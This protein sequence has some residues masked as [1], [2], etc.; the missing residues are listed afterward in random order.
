MAD[1]GEKKP[2]NESAEGAKKPSD[3]NPTKLADITEIPT[4]PEEDLKKAEEAGAKIVAYDPDRIMAFVGGQITLGDLEGIPKE[5]QYAMA[6]A[7]FEYMNEGKLEMAK[8]IFEGL[9]A[10]D[11]FDAYFHTALG[12]V[13]QQMGDL[14]LADTRYTRAIELNPFNATALANRGE[15]RLLKGMMVEATEDIAK[16]LEVDPEAQD[17]AVQRARAIAVSIQAQ[18]EEAQKEGKFEG[19][20]SGSGGGGKTG[21][22]KAKKKAK[23]KT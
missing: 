15:I 3:A 8:Q 7:G 5:D 19:G 11:P 22:K 12:S 18:L 1:E 6:E 16:A 21:K 4:A 13:A 10:L 2:P 20:D 14:D 23:G 17:P 9:M